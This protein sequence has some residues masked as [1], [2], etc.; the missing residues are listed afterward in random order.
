MNPAIY[1]YFNRIDLDSQILYVRRLGQ[2]K[3]YL[4]GSL[5]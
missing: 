3:Q 5:D 1:Y 2:K 4:S